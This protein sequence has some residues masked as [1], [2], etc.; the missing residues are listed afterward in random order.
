MRS[1]GPWGRGSVLARS[2]NVT[3]VVDIQMSNEDSLARIAE[4][5]E[6]EGLEY[7]VIGGHAVNIHGYLRTT[8]DIDFLILTSSLEPWKIALGRIGYRPIHETIVFAQFESDE[9]DFMDLDLMMVD[10]ST[11]SKLWDAS[12]LREY[13]PRKYRVVSLMH[14]IALKLHA[15]RSEYRDSKGKDYFDI[16]SLIKSHRIDV[17]SGEFQDILSRYATEDIRRRLTRDIL[18]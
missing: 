8:A 3:E 13:G 4:A 16:L 7:L 5:A 12:E 11:Y 18:G 6:K 17:G 10:E 2:G 15:L 1:S 14:L 9:E